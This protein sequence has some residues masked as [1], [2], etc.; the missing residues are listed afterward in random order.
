MGIDGES[1]SPHNNYRQKK[2]ILHFQGKQGWLDILK[3]L[4]NIFKLVSS[5]EVE[6]DYYSLLDIIVSEFAQLLPR[7]RKARV[8]SHY[9]STSFMHYLL[10]LL[11]STAFSIHLHKIPNINI[12]TS[13]L[14]FV[15][16]NKLQG[17]CSLSRIN[18]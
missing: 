3:P 7:I 9:R 4:T 13:I 11:P 14:L 8:P 17:N 6:K 15:S 1:T 10:S 5:I 16:R 2:H 12:N 18:R